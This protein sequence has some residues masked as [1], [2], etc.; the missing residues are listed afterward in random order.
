MTYLLVS[1]FVFVDAN[2]RLYLTG[3]FSGYWWYQGGL[4]FMSTQPVVNI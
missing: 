4:V 2:L 1:S 3:F